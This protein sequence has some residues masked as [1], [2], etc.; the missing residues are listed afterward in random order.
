MLVM[1]K[2]VK[3]VR[4]VLI[5]N[6]ASQ[7]IPAIQSRCTRF[8]FSP[9]GKEGCLIRLDKI[10]QAEGINVTPA[11]K[12]ALISLSKGDMR[13]VL[14]VLQAAA[15]TVDKN[16]LIDEDLIYAVTA[17][18]HPSEL[19][20]I[21]DCLMNC[22]NFQTALSTIQKV[23]EENS[24]AMQD[25][26]GA[27]FDRINALQIPAAMRIGLTKQ[28]SDLEYRLTLGTNEALQLQSLIG[29]FMTSRCLMSKT[30]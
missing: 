7:L 24:L 4:F 5:C 2:Y 23:Q 30:I 10:I 16:A 25:I 26:V 17:T 18:P 13:R 21:L 22:T 14:N 6:Y 15:S 9:I 12:E 19:Q 3:H 20:R 27:I 29:L 28:L 11:A 1:E 8:R